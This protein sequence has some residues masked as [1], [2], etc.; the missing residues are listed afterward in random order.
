MCITEHLFSVEHLNLFTWNCSKNET[1]KCRSDKRK[2]GGTQESGWGSS[3]ERLVLVTDIY[4]TFRVKWRVVVRWWYLCLR[5][6][7]GLVSF[8]VMWLVIKNVKVAM[9]GQL[10]FCCYFLSVF[11]CCLFVEVCWFCLIVWRTFL[12]VPPSGGFTWA[13]VWVCVPPLIVIVLF[14]NIYKLCTEFLQ[15][16]QTKLM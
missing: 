11:V 12:A 3:L 14:H 2:E 15:Q 13:W 9:I 1:S 10:L 5:L 8:V 4:T 16:K 7:F 6:W